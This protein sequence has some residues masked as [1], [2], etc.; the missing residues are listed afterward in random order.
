MT[1][2]GDEL[3]NTNYLTALFL[4]DSCIFFCNVM[5]ESIHWLGS[6]TENAKQYQNVLCTPLKGKYK[7]KYQQGK[8]S[9]LCCFNYLKFMR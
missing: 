5:R 8:Y 2:G 9:A 6:Y 1:N 7:K 3:C 4:F